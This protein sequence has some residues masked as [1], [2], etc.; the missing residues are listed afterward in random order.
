MNAHNRWIKQG[1]EDKV[2]LLVG[3][4]ESGAGG[5]ILAHGESKAAL[6]QRVSQDP[7]V[8]EKVVCAEI[9]EITPKKSDSRLAFL[10]NSTSSNT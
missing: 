3:A 6:E 1:F 10:V 9:V 2:F 8:V 4:I 5:A 7:F